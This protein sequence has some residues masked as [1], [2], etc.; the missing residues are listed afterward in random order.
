M[1][2]I[3][4]I[5]EAVNILNKHYVTD[6]AQMVS[7]WIREE[8]LPA[9]RSDNRKI[10]WQILED[11][12]YDFISER[13]PG[14]VEIIAWYE[15]NVLRGTLHED[16]TSINVIGGNISGKDGLEGGRNQNKKQI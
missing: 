4:N 9:D 16:L 2:R 15:E 10:G 1:S 7:R 6:S 11:D 14:I 5:H 3:L 12:L 13:N 8:K